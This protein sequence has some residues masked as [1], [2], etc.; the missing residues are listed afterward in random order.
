MTDF[1]LGAACGFF[2]T[3]ATTRTTILNYFIGLYT[4]YKAKTPNA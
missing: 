3:Q 1:L 2:L 4:A